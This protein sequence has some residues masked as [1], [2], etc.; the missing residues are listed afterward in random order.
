MGSA[1]MA[2]RPVMPAA[3][4]EDV[5]TLPEYRY[6]EIR[7]M[8]DV[9][10]DG[11]LVLLRIELERS[12]GE[13][14]DDPGKFFQVKNGSL[15]RIRGWFADRVFV[16]WLKDATADTE[17]AFRG[18]K[19]TRFRLAELIRAKEITA[20]PEAIRDRSG[21]VVARMN[22]LLD[23]ETGE[24]DLSEIGV[25]EPGDQYSFVAM[26]DPQGGFPDDS[27][28]LKTRMKIHNAFI[29][30][31][32]RLANQLDFQPLFHMVIGDVCDDWGYEKDLA[33]MNQF[34]SRLRSPVLYG[35]G[36]H[37]TLLRSV[38]E[39]GYHMEPFH[40][41]LAA[42]K[43]MNGLEKLLY[44]FNAGRWHYVVWPDPLRD[45]FWETHPHYFD[46][47]ERDLE[48]HR[49][50]PAM[51]FQHVPSHPI[52]ISPH[53][54]YAESV[55]VKRTFLEILARHGNVKVV[56]S[57]HVHIPL[58]ASMK[59]AVSYKGIRLI[60]LP[61][62]GYRPRAFGEEDY[63][64]GPSQGIALVHIRDDQAQIQFK[65]VT[66][67]LFDYPGQLPPFNETSFPLWLQHP[68]ELPAAPHFRNGDFSKGLESWARRYLYMEDSGPSNVC[69]VRNAP[70]LS[71]SSAL[72]LYNRCRG[73]RAPGQDR[74]P[75]DMNRICQAISVDPGST[76][77]ISF[78]YLVD[79]TYFDPGSYTGGFVWIEGFSGSQ[80]TF[81]MMYSAGKIWV[82]IGGKYSLT[83]EF[84]FIQMELPSEPGTWHLAELNPAAD[85]ERA[86]RED[87]SAREDPVADYDR[88]G[89][90][91]NF[92]DLGT[93][94][95]VVHLGVWHIND[96]KEQPFGI[97]FTDLSV[98]GEAEYPSRVDG[99]E[100]GPKP[101]A[102]EWWRNKLWP[103]ANIAG[104]HRY[105]IATQDPKE[106]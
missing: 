16:L 87:P 29:E 66:G 13:M 59:T 46:W 79:A 5:P 71:S 53:I 37:E 11:G 27:E 68:W 101:K 72:Y 81:N 51:V 67:E 56:L 78:R 95:L 28:G 4:P 55:E 2:A 74:L 48:K 90:E 15:E 84:P 89:R 61:A 76:P 31:S 73:Y 12:L 7:S 10:T 99:Q 34:L 82:N 42:Q 102:D 25:A 54:N 23:R 3:G 17:I 8:E 30:E 26:A 47:L 36:N 64:G 50:R 39:P 43:A 41:Y 57:G 77:F 100:T 52:G 38:F 45:R 21:P 83:R 32:V 24:I 93:D 80:K 103:S 44:S 18:R 19:G 106:R 69:E 35:I 85:Y 49:H 60:S 40:H 70:G 63:Y 9:Y 105:I 58:K 6:G 1:A 75:Q 33:Q 91:I 94:R 20:T 96:G 97:W 62:A 65:T 98:T 14:A 92:R 22:F 104:E 86:A 88:P